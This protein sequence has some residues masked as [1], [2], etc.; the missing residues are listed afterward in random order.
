MFYIWVNIDT[1]GHKKAPKS[2]NIYTYNSNNVCVCVCLSVRVS[3]MGTYSFD[4]IEMNFEI[5]K[6]LQKRKVNVILER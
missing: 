4:F 3:A 1:R 5:Q 6:A 2:L